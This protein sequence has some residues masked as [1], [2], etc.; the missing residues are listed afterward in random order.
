[1]AEMIT[2]EQLVEELRYEEE[3][4]SM[5]KGRLAA[6][7]VIL[8]NGDAYDETSDLLPLVLSM[9]VGFMMENREA[10]NEGVNNIAMFPLSIQGLVNSMKYS[11]KESG[12]GDG[13]ANQ[14]S[15]V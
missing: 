2:A 9:L 12:E 15:T 8:K 3:D 5:V 13:E 7:I 4:L 14:D 10:M 6:A 1:M 11:I